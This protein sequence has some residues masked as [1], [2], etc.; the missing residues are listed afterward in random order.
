MAAVSV[1]VL[2]SLLAAVVAPLAVALLQGNQDNRDNKDKKTAL[3]TVQS[4]MRNS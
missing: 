1:S 3:S 4:A 2:G